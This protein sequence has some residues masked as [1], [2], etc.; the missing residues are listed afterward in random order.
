MSAPYVPKNPEVVLQRVPTTTDP[1]VR[2]FDTLRAKLLHHPNDSKL[3]VKLAKAYLDYGRGTGDARF[4][5]R[6]LAVI[7]PWMKR[8]P[9]PVSVAVVHATALQSR[10]HFKASRREL[11]KILSRAPGNSQ[12]WLTLATV[13]MVQA[14]YRLAN[15]ACVH[16]A[17]T[18]GDFMGI[19]C[20]GELRG[21]TGHARQA[22]ALL[23]LIEH[24][25]DR[26]PVGVKAYI[27][28]LMADMAKRLGNAAAADKHYRRALQLTPGD[29]FLL[30]DYGDFLLDQARPKV[31][32]ELVKNYSASDTSFMRQV[33]AE[34]ALG[35]P[36]A[37]ADIKEMAAR[38]A[39]MDRRH[40]HVYRREEARFVLYLQHNPQR[41][42]K[43]ARQNWTVQ[44]APKDMRIYLE[45]ALAADRPQAAE[46]VLELLTTSHLQDPAVNALARKARAA[47]ATVPA[48]ATASQ[49]IMT[50]IER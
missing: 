27:E 50:E 16:A 8:S 23:G 38:F 36:K 11:K 44:R 21:L 48:T 18:G 15:K 37:E 20:T 40:T 22:Y 10:H 14:D 17:Q 2:Q 19:M 13:A 24:S 41:A 28:G 46:P 7:A 32:L 1:R 30:A 4:I 39:A 31:A 43:L 12:A 29:N 35:S 26:V 45:A 33:F 3:A 49:A 9:P 6:S 42:L 34:A 47:I 5:G 25:G